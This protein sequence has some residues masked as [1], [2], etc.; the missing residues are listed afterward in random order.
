[1]RNARLFGALQQLHTSV[2]L[3]LAN[4]SSSVVPESAFE[5]LYAA[6]SS[7]LKLA[8]QIVAP[9]F[10]KFRELAEATVLDV[11]RANFAREEPSSA[12]MSHTAPGD[13]ATM[14]C[15]AYMS[16]LQSQLAY[17]AGTTLARYA[18]CDLLGERCLRVAQRLMS[19]LVRHLALV[20]PL[21]SAGR[22]QMVADLAQLEAGLEPL[23]AHTAAAVHLAQQQH[24]APNN[25][26]DSV[27]A[28]A[29]RAYGG[30]AYKQLRRFRAALFLPPASLLSAAN[31]GLGYIVAIHMLF[32]LA[33][34][35]L[36]SPHRAL[37][38][39]V[40]RYSQ[41]LDEHDDAAV[42]HQIRD[43]SLAALDDATLLGDAKLKSLVDVMRKLGAAI[44]SKSQ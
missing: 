29:L 6:L 7:V 32:A 37:Q 1:M 39:T 28:G 41:F 40:G 30:A 19:F 23:V 34:E 22:M 26:D 43:S 11:H 44:E 14:P 25:N 15:S 24:S 16:S 10:G 20:R 31:D 17:F 4:M 13:P 36:A 5:P 3:V 33:P 9:L 42:W 35:Q 27:G 8:D 12:S 18:P 21:G 38:W 2:A